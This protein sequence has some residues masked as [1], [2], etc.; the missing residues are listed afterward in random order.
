MYQSKNLEVYVADQCNLDCVGC[1]HES[2]FMT[3]RFEDPDRVGRAL[4]QLWNYYQAPLVKLLGGEPLLHPDIH[5]VISVVK[6]RTG[7]VIRIV[8]NGTLLK[9]RYHLLN[10]ANE[11][12]ISSYPNIPIPN[13]SELRTI[14]GY[15]GASITV[16]AFGYFR[17]HRSMP[18][19]DFTLTKR[20]FATCQMFHSWQCHTLRDSRFYG[21]PPSATWASN[22]NE[23]VNLLT[24]DSD[25]QINIQT[26]LHRDVP[27]ASCKEC[28]GSAGQRFVHQIG[29]GRSRNTQSKLGLDLNF[30]HALEFNPDAYNGCFEYQRTI[31]PS[32]YTQLYGANK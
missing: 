11:I 9:Q 12:H 18:S 14:A 16:Q 13:D 5:E 22:N 17:W 1:S 4:S 24:S 27:F 23:G 3:R 7:A 15:L 20:V 8:T 28:L 21:C 30:L 29:W 2:P 6:A 31:H 32:G 10:G 25:L 19:S 26:M